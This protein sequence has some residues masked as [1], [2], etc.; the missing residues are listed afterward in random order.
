MIFYVVENILVKKN[1]KKVRKTR[2]SVRESK[3]RHRNNKGQ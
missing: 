3:K 2:A 1:A